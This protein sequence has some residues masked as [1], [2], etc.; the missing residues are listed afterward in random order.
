[1]RDSDTFMEDMI[2]AWLQREDQ[3]LKRGVPTWNTLVKDLRD[4]RVNQTEIADR[5][6]AEKLNVPK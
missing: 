4:P 3:V 5:I 2:Y 1:M 6:E